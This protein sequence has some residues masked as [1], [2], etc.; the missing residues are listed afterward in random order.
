MLRVISQLFVIICKAQKHQALFL[1]VHPLGNVSELF[2]PKPMVFGYGSIVFHL[3]RP[4]CE[5]T[6]SAHAQG[7]TVQESPTGMTGNA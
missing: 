3:S 1:L 7:T 4:I 2:S 6:K 5:R